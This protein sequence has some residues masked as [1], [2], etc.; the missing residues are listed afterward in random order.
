[1]AS[2]VSLQ[3]MTFEALYNLDKDAEACSLAMQLA[4]KQKIGFGFENGKCVPL[5]E[6]AREKWLTGLFDDLSRA[7]T[8]SYQQELFEICGW[9]FDGEEYL[10]EASE[11]D[12]W[13]LSRRRR[14]IGL[15]T[16]CGARWSSRLWPEKSWSR[17]AL[18]LKK[19]GYTVVLLG[20]PD[21]HERNRRLAKSTGAKYFGHFPLARFINLM[22]QCDLVVTAVTMAMHLAIG[23]KKKI[24][25]FNNIFNRNEFELYGRGVVLEPERA[26]RC[27]YLPSCT[28]TRSCME[29]LPVETVLTHCKRLLSD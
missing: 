29:T 8:K 9:S 23:L 18:R 25:V 26:C 24:V 4:A 28:Q 15:N 12:P 14:V 19:A 16:G 21:E 13:P 7:N 5:N 11:S 3:G 27:F 10:L 1:L 20:G 17:L 2:L 6:E 22:D